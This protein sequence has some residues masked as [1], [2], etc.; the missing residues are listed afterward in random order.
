M[1]GE[2]VSAAVIADVVSDADG[3][4]DVALSRFSLVVIVEMERGCGDGMGRGLR[5]VRCAGAF[6][7][8]RK[9]LWDWDRYM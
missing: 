8:R 9:P 6:L 2:C 7:S 1:R 4:L 5:L 3:V